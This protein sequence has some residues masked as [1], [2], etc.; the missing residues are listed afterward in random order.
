MIDEEDNIFLSIQE[1]LTREVP[2]L[3]QVKE[4][5]RKEL[6]DPEISLFRNIRNATLAQWDTFNVHCGMFEIPLQDEMLQ[7]SNKKKRKVHARRSYHYKIGCYET[8]L[9]YTKYL[10]N[11]IV[12]IPGANDDTVRNQTKRLSLN[13]K[14]TFRSW[15]K[16]PLYK[17]E[18]L[19]EQLLAD[20]IIHLSHHCQNDAR[21]RIKSELLVLGALAILSGSVNGFRKLPLVTHIC[22]TDHSTFFKTFV[23]YLF[24]NRAKYI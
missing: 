18:T 8:S 21:L 17:V 2:T 3:S 20:E 24:D 14:S 9:Y 15:F 5:L 12:Q 11:D 10:S 19:A 7:P 13:S 6:G 23:K 16:M 1:E 4:S 22:A